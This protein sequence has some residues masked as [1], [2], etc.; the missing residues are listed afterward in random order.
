VVNQTIVSKTANSRPSTRARIV[1]YAME[2]GTE[3][4]A[5][6][7]P[8]DRQR[9]PYEMP[10]AKSRPAPEQMP[11]DK[12]SRHISIFDKAATIRKLLGAWRSKGDFG[13]AWRVARNAPKAEASRNGPHDPGSHLVV[14]EG[15]EPAG[16]GTTGRPGKAPRA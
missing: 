14:F 11:Y 7:P 15:R 5:P 3:I 9:K 12:R 10:L 2:T 6:R 13:L 1:C 4:R 8:G 16:N